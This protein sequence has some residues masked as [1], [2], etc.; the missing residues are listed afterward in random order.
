MD[1]IASFVFGQGVIAKIYSREVVHTFEADSVEEA[2]EAAFK[3]S[4][5]RTAISEKVKDLKTTLVWEDDAKGLVYPETTETAV[6]EEEKPAEETEAAA[7]TE[8]PLMVGTCSDEKCGYTG[9]SDDFPWTENGN[10]CPTCGGPA[11]FAAFEPAEEVADDVFLKED[12]EPAKEEDEDDGDGTIYKEVK[13]EI[14][15]INKTVAGLIY[16]LELAQDK[17]NAEKVA[18][19]SLMKDLNA[20]YDVAQKKLFQTRNGYSYTTVECE[21]VMDYEA[22]VKHITRK[23]T[24]EVLEDIDLTQAEIQLNALPV[25]EATEEVKPIEMQFAFDSSKQIDVLKEEEWIA[26]TI[27]K[28]SKGDRFRMSE[29]GKKIIEHEGSTQFL[30]ETKPRRV[31]AEKLFKFKVIP[32]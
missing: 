7:D 29:D 6:E 26:T 18:H 23:D 22:G 12:L 5:I 14:T 30:V 1:L 15:D 24:G 10:L 21:A 2:K 9:P 31:N 19:S 20:D 4:G 8:E 32:C 27:A 11:T 28:L 17:I 3:N 13:I 16:D 25:E